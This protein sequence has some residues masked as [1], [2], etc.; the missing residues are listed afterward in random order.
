MYGY[1]QDPMIGVGPPSVQFAGMATQ[2]VDNTVFGAGAGAYTSGSRARMP[3]TTSFPSESGIGRIYD[4]SNAGEGFFGGAIRRTLARGNTNLLD[5][6]HV[7]VA[8]KIAGP[9]KFEQPFVNQWFD[10]TAMFCVE[11][12]DVPSHRPISVSTGDSSPVTMLNAAQLS[13]AMRD[14]AEEAS[15]HK[16]AVG[17]SCPTPEVIPASDKPKA[18]VAKNEVEWYGDYEKDGDLRK[19]YSDEKKKKLLWN[20]INHIGKNVRF[21][22][23]FNGMAARETRVD[24]DLAVSGNFKV[25]NYW[26]KDAKIGDWVGFIIR[27]PTE[28]AKC[29]AIVVES[30]RSHDFPYP[31]AYRL[32]SK[33]WVEDLPYVNAAAFIPVG[34]I[35]DIDPAISNA[36]LP[37]ER[38][39]EVESEQKSL[40]GMSQSSSQKYD[41]LQEYVRVAKSSIRNVVVNI[42]AVGAFVDASEFITERWVKAD[43]VKPGVPAKPIPEAAVGSE[44]GL[45]FSGFSTSAPAS[46]SARAQVVGSLTV[47]SA[48]T[49]HPRRS[50]N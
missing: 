48:S 44:F 34:I 47:P 37:K 15:V 25:F 4:G 3:A 35:C 21:A 20:N 22:G 12:S 6:K 5:A 9:N 50:G 13:F 24:V 23:F 27:R 19:E 14:A 40:L 7:M 43:A 32:Q 1:Q 18:V 38:V 16:L 28:T 49:S 2:Y 36:Y 33:D 45:D 8:A 26:G 10:G 46:E 42:G 17:L 39:D 31:A 41:V 11:D 30:W 29:N